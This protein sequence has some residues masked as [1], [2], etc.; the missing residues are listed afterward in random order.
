MK[1]DCLSESEVSRLR[2]PFM[3]TRAHYL[4]SIASTR[5]LGG[6][7]V[8]NDPAAAP[9]TAALFAYVPGAERCVLAR[10]TKPSP[11]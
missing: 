5:V 6:L 11:P 4:H 10:G 7:R 2:T 9:I 8:I 3:N 1:I